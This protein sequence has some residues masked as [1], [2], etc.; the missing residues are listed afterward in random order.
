VTNTRG[1]TDG[2][3]PI[4]AR[5]GPTLET[6]DTGASALLRCPRCAATFTL[7][8]ASD[9]C[10]VCDIDDPNA[11]GSPSGGSGG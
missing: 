11:G 9:R 2:P 5:P 1:A 3:R 6:A 8:T 4:A 7:T 10:P